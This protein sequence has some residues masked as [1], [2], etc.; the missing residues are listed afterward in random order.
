MNP[1]LPMTIARLGI[2]IL[3]AATVLALASCGRRASSAAEAP[4]RPVAS[5]VDLSPLPSGT[6][7]SQ[8]ALS[9]EVR[10]STGRVLF[11]GDT[12]G[13]GRKLFRARPD[14]R[15]A[16]TGAQLVEP[17]GQLVAEVGAG[18]RVTRLQVV[19]PSGTTL[20]A[21]VASY[22]ALYGP[23]TRLFTLTGELEG[24]HWQDSATELT[25]QAVKR[26]GQ[27]TVLSQLAEKA[28]T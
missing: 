12:L 22:E 15:L 16:L 21:L 23:G 5:Q 19:H 13:T 8:R 4:P 1:Q 17:S 27:T 10:L 6:G 25:V 3:G 2:A 7:G 9:R 14:G 18:D 28:G 11:L 26:A 20:D 24:V